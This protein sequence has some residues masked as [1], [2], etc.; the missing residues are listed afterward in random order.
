MN[1]GRRA[2]RSDLPIR[3]DINVTSLVDVAFTLLVIFIITAPML[4][5]GVQVNVPEAHVAP[6][7]HQDEPFMISVDQEG[8]VFLAETEVAMEEFETSVPQ[9]LRAAQ[10]EMVYIKGDSLAGYGRVLQVIAAVSR[11]EGIEFSLVAD[12]RPVERR[13]P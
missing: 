10:A 8:R 13:R 9:M 3:A 12:P 2:A 7:T 4:Q 11:V 6:L 1:G 5:G